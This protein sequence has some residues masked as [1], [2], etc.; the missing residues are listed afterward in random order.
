M[1]GT[2]ATTGGTATVTVT[3]GGSGLSGNAGSGTAASAG[4]D[5]A[6]QSQTFEGTRVPLDLYVML[7][8]SDSMLEETGT[9]TKW[10]AVGGAIRS[11]VNDTDSAGIGIGLQFL[12]LLNPDAPSVCHNDADC[13]G[14]GVCNQRFCQNA[15][16]DFYGCG[17]DSDCVF[18]GEDLGPCEMLTH[19]WSN[20]VATGNIALCH[21]DLECGLADDCIPFAHCGDDDYRFCNAPGLACS[22]NYGPCVEEGIPSTC[23][24]AVSCDTDTYAEPA[25]AIATLPA[26]APAVIT[27][28]TDHEPDGNTP[29]APAL[30]GAIQQ[31]HDW[32][33]AQ[34]DHQVAVVLA[35]DGLP[36][37]CIADPDGD[38][39]GILGVTAAAAAGLTG[40][41]SIRTFVIGVFASD[42]TDAPGNLDQIAK[43]GGTKQ[44]FIVTTG[45]ADDVQEQFVAA[46]DSIRG[47]GISCELQIPMPTAGTTDFGRVNVFFTEADG[48]SAEVLYYAGD[49]AGCESGKGDWYYGEDDDGHPTK[50]I[51]CPATC[52]RFQAASGGKVT[53]GVGCLTVVR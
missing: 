23:E 47:S 43:A 5:G 3:G 36:S 9:A 8:S 18:N 52:A 14:F 25:V 37:E 48:D 41:P 35:T 15:G 2:T 24:D 49:E 30:A 16:P 32:A 11:F 50:I 28:I 20:L 44:A 38:P 21:N 39:G 6:C 4:L 31:A 13:T 45:N 29:S 34:A 1:G 19:C 53:I 10:D 22:G 42:E 7:D 26:V 46:L 12:P 27:A 51:A 40:T 33:V 17:R